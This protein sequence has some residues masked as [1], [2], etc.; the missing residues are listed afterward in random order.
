MNPSSEGAMIA[1]EKLSKYYGAFVA[2]KDITFSI[3]KGQIVAF[4]GPNGAGKSTTMR[5]L[6]CFMPASE[7]EA[8][9][10]GRHL[11]NIAPCLYGLRFRVSR[12][13]APST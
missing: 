2:I 12:S 8:H 6:T 5:I 13:L 10:A 4:L 9:V 11:D 7:G 3:P 1:A